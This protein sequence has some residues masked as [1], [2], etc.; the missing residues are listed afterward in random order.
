[1]E[2][3]YCDNNRHTV[4]VWVKSSRKPQ[5][6]RLCGSEMSNGQFNP[7]Y[8]NVIILKPG[9]HPALDGTEYRVEKSIILE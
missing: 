9:I 4:Q 1:M 6:C 8:I 5:L 7:D 2:Y 3:Y